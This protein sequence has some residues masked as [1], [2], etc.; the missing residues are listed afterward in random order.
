MVLRPFDFAP[1]R[2][3]EID[4]PADIEAARRVVL[5]DGGADAR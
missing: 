5:G 4:R 2:W 1:H 3:Q